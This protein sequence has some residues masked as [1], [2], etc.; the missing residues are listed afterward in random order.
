MRITEV[1]IK[2]ADDASGEQGDRLLGFA[3]VCI[4]N[5]FVVRDLKLITGK[6][7]RFVA[8]P[9]RSLKDHCPACHGKTELRAKYCQHCG[10]RLAADRAAR[11]PETG[12]ARL[13]ADHAHPINSATRALITGFVLAA[14]DREVELAR[15]PGYVCSYDAPHGPRAVAS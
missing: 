3:S 9:S 10:Q 6:G 12:K 13:Y 11:D 5:A 14:Y 7:G 1:R 15:R 2:L 8:M 4:D